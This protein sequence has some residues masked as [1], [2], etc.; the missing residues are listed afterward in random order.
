MA[1]GKLSQSTTDRA[2][3]NPRRPPY[4]CDPAISGC[5]DLRRRKYPATSFVPA[6]NRSRIGFSSIIPRA[7]AR[8]HRPRIPRPKKT[9]SRF[10][11]SLT[12]PYC[13]IRPRGD[14]VD[15]IHCQSR[16]GP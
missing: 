4:C 7:Y 9:P 10:T 15:D 14:F 12:R 3:G 2:R 5:L 8:Q 6:A 11:Y 16:I 13:K 1:V